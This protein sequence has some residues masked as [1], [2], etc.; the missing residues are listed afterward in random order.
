MPHDSVRHLRSSIHGPL[1]F[2][3][4]IPPSTAVVTHET[5]SHTHT[6]SVRLP[7]RRRNDTAIPPKS[8]PNLPCNNNGPRLGLEL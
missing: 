3:Q 2:E 7:I 4:Q 5:P 8:L 1:F 6:D